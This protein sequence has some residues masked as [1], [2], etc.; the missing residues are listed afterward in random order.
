M[1]DVNLRGEKVFPVP[2]ELLRQQMP[3]AFTTG[4]GLGGI[5]VDLRTTPVAVKPFSPVELKRV[6]TSALSST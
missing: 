6:L 2:D 3:F 1:L 5:R 4:Y